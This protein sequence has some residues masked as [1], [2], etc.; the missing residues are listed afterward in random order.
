[1]NELTELSGYDQY[2]S[3]KSLEEKFGLSNYFDKIISR[4][5]DGAACV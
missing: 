2:L 1:M 3:E 4:G 5:G